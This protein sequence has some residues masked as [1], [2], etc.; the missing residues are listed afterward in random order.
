MRSDI[1]KWE[2]IVWVIQAKNVIKQLKNYSISNKIHCIY[3]LGSKFE[4]FYKV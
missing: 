2:K 1:N 4:L 3:K